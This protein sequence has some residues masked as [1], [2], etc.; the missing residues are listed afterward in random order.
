[1]RTPSRTLLF[2]SLITLNLFSFSAYSAT[3]QAE[4]IKKHD[5]AI[6]SAH[7]AATAAGMQML[8]LGGNAFDAAIA[9]SAVLAVVEP[10]SSGIGGGGFWLLHRESDQKQIMIDGRE[11]APGKAHEKMYLD[12]DGEV[13]PRSSLD[14]PLAAGIPGTIAALVHLAENYGTLPLAQSL[15]PA[16]DAAE[17]GFVVTPLYQ[18]MV[19]FRLA[20]LQASAESARIFL[21]ENAVP[22]LG[23]LII[24]KDLANTLQQVAELGGAGFYKGELAEKLVQ[25]SVAEGGIWTLDDLASYSIVEREPV[26]GTYKDFTIISAALPSSG[27]AVLVQTLNMLERK[28]LENYDVITRKHVVIEAMKRAYRD[29][30]VYMGDQDF[31]PFPESIL[32]KPYAT[33]K[34]A[35]IQPDRATPVDAHKPSI[36][37]RGKGTDTTHFSVVDQAGNRVA[38]TLS[39]N[40]PFG[41]GFTVPGTGVL[42]NDE[43]DDFSINAGTPNAYELVGGKANAIEA[44]KRPLSSMTPTFIESDDRIAII[45]TPGG[46]RIISMVILGA[47]DM[48]ASK[49]VESWVSLPRYHHQYLPDVV[50]FE[51]GGLTEK[52]QTA[53]KAKGHQL[54]ELSRQYGNMHA[55]LI[56]KTVTEAGDQNVIRVTAASDPRG[57]GR[58]QVSK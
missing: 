55:I 25:G 47:L 19:G 52:E 15:A 46:S 2:S 58:A 26:R 14:G 33:M 1:M 35:G 57:E 5:A 10:Y 18:K 28:P 56:E 7:P 42:L 34:A 45:G 54:R 11:K 6:A 8:E 17:K 41:S 43:M 20:A 39:I 21:R 37:P 32:T 23:E 49:P 12:A 3:P 24:Q 22:E 4:Q 29:R 51:K 27:G 9:V 36:S 16:I 30:A 53:L 38:A 48:M 13:I 31:V 44:G 50:Q 40:Y